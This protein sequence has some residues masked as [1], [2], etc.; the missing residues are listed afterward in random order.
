MAVADHAYWL[1]GLRVRSD[2]HG[3]IDAR[4]EAFGTGDPP[5]VKEQPTA[6]TLTGGTRPLTYVRRSQSWGPA[7]S[8]P[9]QNAL[10]LR[11]TN[12]GAATVTGSRAR[13]T[14]N[15]PLRVRLDSDGDGSVRLDVALPAGA[16]V[17]RIEGPPVPGGEPEVQLD[18][19]GATFR[20]AEGTRT[21]LISPP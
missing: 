21:Y 5:V 2:G 10:N 7:P 13:L 20:V 19:G 16:T 17:E 6:G 1:S 8:T 3:T 14:G 9:Q 15:E 18:P 11:L 12:I 4:S